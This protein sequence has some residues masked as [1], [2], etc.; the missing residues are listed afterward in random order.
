MLPDQPMCRRSSDLRPRSCSG[1]TTSE[2][3]VLDVLS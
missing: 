1:S 3:E 2:D